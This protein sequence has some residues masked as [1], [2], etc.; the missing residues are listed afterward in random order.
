M[1]VEKRK[2]FQNKRLG[3]DLSDPSYK[4]AVASKV[5][6]AGDLL[7]DESPLCIS[8]KPKYFSKVCHHCFSFPKDPLRCSS[9]KYTHY[10]SKEHQLADWNNGHKKECAFMK[11]VFEEMGHLPEDVAL[12]IKIHVQ[13]EVLKNEEF[14][15]AFDD[16]KS[17]KITIDS[18]QVNK[19]V[20]IFKKAANITDDSSETDERY[21]AFVS[22]IMVNAYQHSK[23][24]GTQQGIIT[25]KALL[26][27]ISW[28]NHSCRP[29]C[30]LIE[31]DGL[32]QRIYAMKP[33]KKGE[34]LTV[35]YVDFIQRLETRRAK[36][37]HLLFECNCKRCQEE[38]NDPT[39]HK[40]CKLT[41]EELETTFDCAKAV[42]KF[43]REAGKKLDEFD[44]EWKLI[45]DRVEGPMLD[46]FKDY[47]WMLEFETSYAKKLLHWLGDITFTTKLQMHYDTMGLVL[48]M[49][50]RMME[51]AEY[52]QGYQW[53]VSLLN[54]K[55][56]YA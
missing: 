37:K 6:S 13:L 23:N 31:G 53:I 50:G 18:D 4:K 40:T 56:E 19:I 27:K 21:R 12:L 15:K 44:C 9:C 41:Q 1:Q 46:Q 55:V 29:N 2:V 28:F 7:L 5:L 25:S 32:Q 34:E 52:Q 38:E 16:L 11:K 47:A 20:I 43:V 49:N 8:V 36:L 30:L 33:I 26:H 14:K 3:F 24:T 22:K 10:C 42:K 39:Y 35:A 48:S 54:Q 45:H 51:T 17:A